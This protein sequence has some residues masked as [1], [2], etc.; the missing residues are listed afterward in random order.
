MKIQWDERHG[1]ILSCFLEQLSNNGIRWFILRGYEDL[2]N[3]NPS[4]D[5]DI[6]VE[7]GQ[8]K[9]MQ[10]IEGSFFRIW[11]EVFLFGDIWSRPLLF[12]NGTGHTIFYSHRFDRGIYLKRI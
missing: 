12:G 6:M 10:V 9:G 5:V 4:K 7:V 8:E 1:E 3:A 2:P 11:I